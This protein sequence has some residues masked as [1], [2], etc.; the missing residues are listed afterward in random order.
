[1]W[2]NSGNS[3]HDQESELHQSHDP[4]KTGEGRR[5]SSGDRILIQQCP[6]PR[7]HPMSNHAT[8]RRC[9]LCA[10]VRDSSSKRGCSRWFLGV[11]ESSRGRIYSGRKQLGRAWCY[12]QRDSGVNPPA[13]VSCAPLG[14]FLT[15]SDSQLSSVAGSNSRSIVGTPCNNASY[16]LSTVPGAG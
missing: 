3:L 2:D 11:P 6:S 5:D 1:M 7:G 8:Q 10:R 15:F 14:K 12:S 9:D 4:L 13:L 16:A